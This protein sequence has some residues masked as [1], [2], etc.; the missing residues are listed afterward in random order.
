MKKITFKKLRLL[1]FCGIREAQYEFG[2]QITVISGAN[3]AGK[4]SVFNALTYVLFGKGANG[5][6]LDIKTF[7][8][9]HNII[10]EIPH[11]VE[12]S[13]LA[14]EEEITLKRTL[15]DVWKGEQVSNTYK[16]YVNGDITT[17]G[18]FKKAVEAICPEVTF[19]LCSSATDFV[20][21]PW[22]EQ[23]KFLEQL[24]PEVTADTVA[25]GEDKYDF[26]VEALKKESI[27]KLLHHLKY[28]RKEIQG[29]LDGIPTRLSELNKAIPEK[30]DWGSLQQEKEQ[31]NS[32]LV[33]IDNK[34]QRIRTG[35]ADTVIK[36]GIRKKIEFAEKRKRNMAQSALNLSTEAATK[37]QS[38]VLTS[39]AA[40]S[41]A[42]SM[43]DELKAKMKGYTEA[44]TQAK[45]QKEECEQRVKDLNDKNAEVTSRAWKWNAEDGICPHCGQVL[46]LADVRRIKQES[47]QNFNARKAEDLKKLQQ[48][49]EKLQQEYTEIKKLLEQIDEERQTTTN[50]LVEAHKV[51]KEAEFHKLEVEADEPDTF[52]EIL[53]KKDEYQLVLGEIA[54]LESRLSEP[55]STSEDDKK[56]LAKLEEEREPIGLRYNEVL[57][58]LATKETY[59]RISDLIEKAQADKKQY[60][61]QLDELDEKVDI[62]SEFNKLSCSILEDKINGQFGYVKWTLFQTSLDGETKPYCECY[63]DGVPYSRLNGAAKVNAGIDIAYTIARFYGVSVPIVLDECESN[64]H[65]IYRGGQQIRLC[66]A[67][68]EG[69]KFDYLAPA[70]E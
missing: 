13:L 66:V 36:E 1:N 54:E 41:K 25:N 39:N 19:R 50:Q 38:D 61:S 35:C 68:N 10:K 22:A 23:R 65:P 59:D 45:A 62:A 29:Q 16:Y 57:N 56:F 47:E 46:P 53:A 9:D 5:L 8:K 26:V 48:D 55:S 60:Q 69:L 33:E 52:E 43:V 32:K 17:A 42:Q 67:P 63:H 31:L 20:S 28:R 40:V 64:L 30:Q 49:F 34:M 4:S 11:E 3:G 14:D 44:E 37:H 18:D 7:D 2:D 70:T 6:A 15:T 21:R 27:D 24:V 12:L 58:L 51:L